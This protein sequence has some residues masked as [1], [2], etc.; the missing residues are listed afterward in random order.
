MF[1]KKKGGLIEARKKK[2]ERARTQ[3]RT[4]FTVLTSFGEKKNKKGLAKAGPLKAGKKEGRG[5]GGRRFGGFFP[6]AACVGEKGGL[7]RAPCGDGTGGKKKKKKSKGRA[8]ARS[9]RTSFRR[10]FSY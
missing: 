5:E 6:V 10:A 8:P 9:A 1:L 7:K 3:G 2:R 4:F